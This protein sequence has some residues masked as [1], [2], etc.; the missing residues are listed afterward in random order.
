[1]RPTTQ[2]SRLMGLHGL[3]THINYDFSVFYRWFTAKQDCDTNMNKPPIHSNI[4]LLEIQDCKDNDSSTQDN[5]ILQISHFLDPKNTNENELKALIVPSKILERNSAWCFDIVIPSHRRS[6]CFT[7]S[8]GKFI[9]GTGSVLYIGT[10]TA[11]KCDKGESSNHHVVT[12]E[13]S[14]D[15][16]QQVDDMKDEEI[17]NDEKKF[18][19]KSP[20]ERT[21]VSNWQQGLDLQNNL[22]YLSGLEIACLMGFPVLSNTKVAHGQRHFSFPPD[23]TLK[24]QWKLLGNSLNVMVASKITEAAILLLSHSLYDQST[25]A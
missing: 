16:S 1:M 12:Q 23:S 21:F 22:R 2:D 9:R 14:R 4:A 7:Q 5:N 17:I 25:I 3:V 19:L 10:T 8:Y 24:Q 6:S 15:T 11:E 20:E 18:E 13:T